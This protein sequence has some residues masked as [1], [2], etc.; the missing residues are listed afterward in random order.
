MDRL[1]YLRD[2]FYTGVNEGNIGV[3]RIINMMNVTD[4]RLVLKKRN[5][6]Y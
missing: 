3:E 6:F 1:D 5:T 4:E 2:S